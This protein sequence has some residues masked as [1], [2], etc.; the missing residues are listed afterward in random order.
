MLETYR[1]PQF[2]EAESLDVSRELIPIF[3]R[4]RT[5]RHFSPEKPS[6]ELVT[7]AIKIAGTA[8]SGANKQPWSFVVIENASLKQHLRDLAEKEEYRF[9]VEKPNE[10]WIKDLSHLHVQ[11]EKKFMTEAPYLIAIFYRHFDLDEAGEKSTNYYAKESAGIAT[12]MLISA[13]HLS[14]LSTL[15]YTPKRMGFLA[16]ELGKPSHER[17]FMLL[18][19]GLPHKEAEVPTISKKSLEEIC[20]TYLN[21]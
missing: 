21:N 11:K 17:T 15:T 20:D 1:T 7:N 3:Q 16:E 6:L 13:L 4:R 5:I 8:P 18:G 2:K 14:G 9:Y 10:K 19:V 12:G